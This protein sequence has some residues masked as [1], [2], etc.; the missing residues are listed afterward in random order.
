MKTPILTYPPPSHPPLQS[1]N[2]LTD[3]NLSN[4]AKLLNPNQVPIK[5]KIY[6][7][8]AQGKKDMTLNTVTV[9]DGLIIWI[10]IAKNVLAGWKDTRRRLP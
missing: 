1:A 3:A 4:L 7:G 2:S 8:V 9:T 5:P 6:T 10:T